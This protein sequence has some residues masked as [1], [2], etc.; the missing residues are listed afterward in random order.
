MQCMKKKFSSLL[1][2]ISSTSIKAGKHRKNRRPQI[3]NF[4]WSPAE[5]L[6]SQKSFKTTVGSE[7][8]YCTI[9]FHFKLLRGFL[10]G[11]ADSSSW[12]SPPHRWHTCEV[13]KWS[14]GSEDGRWGS[15]CPDI[16][17]DRHRTDEQQRWQRG[18]LR[19]LQ[20]PAWHGILFRKKSAST[21]YTA[22]QPPCSVVDREWFVP[23]PNI[24]HKE[25]LEKGLYLF[26][27]FSLNW[28]LPYLCNMTCLS[29]YKIAKMY[30]FVCK[31][32]GS[33]SEILFGIRLPTSRFGSGWRS[34][35]R[36]PWWCDSACDRHSSF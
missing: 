2:F 10:G 36:P 28:Y 1:C 33:S 17:P 12:G 18:W 3:K 29:K 9:R 15:P 22:A 8:L 30:K 11:P 23:D 20:L 5:N 7:H 19:E 14:R 24:V 21:L 34:T 4:H 26:C 31:K 6:V 16:V 27:I 13:C 25:E 32:I 35:T